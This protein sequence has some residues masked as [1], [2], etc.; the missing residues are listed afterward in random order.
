LQR[1]L[2]IIIE[3]H[4]NGAVL[5]HFLADC[6]ALTRLRIKLMPPPPPPEQ[7]K[8]TILR[9]LGTREMT[10]EDI[11]AAAPYELRY[12]GLELTL[13]AMVVLHRLLNERTLLCIPGGL[14]TLYSVKQ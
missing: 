3:R 10:A 7:V 9:V 5:P 6:A 1:A 12:V 4:R 11:R 14:K 8:R 2:G 13:R